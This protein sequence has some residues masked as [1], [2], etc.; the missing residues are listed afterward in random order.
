MV[1][2]VAIERAERRESMDTVTSAETGSS[3]TRLSRIGT[4]IQRYVDEGKLAGLIV[5]VA[6]RGNVVYLG[7]FGD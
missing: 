7:R 6:R 1:Q 3:A 5:M 4:V 2:P